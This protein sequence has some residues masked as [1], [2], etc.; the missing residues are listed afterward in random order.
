MKTLKICLA[1]IALTGCTHAPSSWELLSRAQLSALVSGHT[2]YAPPCPNET[3]GLL[4]YLANDGTGWLD[5]AIVPGQPPRPSEMSMILGRGFTDDSRLCVLA[6]PHIRDMPSF[7][8]AFQVCLKV[9]RSFKRSASGLERVLDRR[10]FATSCPLAL[11]PYNAFPP[12]TIDEYLE[13][14]RVLYGGQVPTWFS[15]APVTSEQ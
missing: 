15:S 4:L 3:Y 6:S 10:T 9:L 13:Q 2:V 1:A 7:A 11:Y 12:R 8:P 14:V 5:T